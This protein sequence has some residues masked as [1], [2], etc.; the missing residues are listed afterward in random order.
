MGMNLPA[1]QFGGGDTPQPMEQQLDLGHPSGGWSLMRM[2]RTQGG[3]SEEVMSRIVEGLVR[4]D[5]E[6]VEGLRHLDEVTLLALVDRETVKRLM[7]RQKRRGTVEEWLKGYKMELKAVKTL[8]LRQV[9]DANEKKVAASEA[10]PL[11]M[12]LEPKQDG[13]KKGRLILLGYQGCSIQVEGR[14]PQL[15]QYGVSV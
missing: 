6:S 7:K 10:I 5:I 8:R 13:R 2:M 9:E 3:L 12:I 14:L 4:N 1:P 15:L 11:R